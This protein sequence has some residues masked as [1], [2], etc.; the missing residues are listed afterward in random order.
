MYS[1]V[2]R[3]ME[4]VWRLSAVFQNT[5]LGFAFMGEGSEIRAKRSGIKSAFLREVCSVNGDSDR[6]FLFCEWR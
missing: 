1:N 6:A 5:S 4:L 2:A 3:L